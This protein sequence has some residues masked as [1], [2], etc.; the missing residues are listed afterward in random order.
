MTVAPT[1]DA[2]MPQRTMLIMDRCAHGKI[3]PETFSCATCA[4]A[5]GK[6]AGRE[7]ALQAFSKA[8]T[9]GEIVEL[10]VKELRKTLAQLPPV[11]D[12]KEPNQ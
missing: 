3:A 10:V 2:R 11:Q 4:Y 9:V 5:A 1:I 6:D 8:S 12:A 7:E